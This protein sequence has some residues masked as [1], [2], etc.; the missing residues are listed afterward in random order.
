MN[1][2]QLVAE[3]QHKIDC[4]EYFIDE[5]WRMVLTGKSRPLSE[6][7]Y[8]SFKTGDIYNFI[9]NRLPEAEPQKLNTEK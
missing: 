8:S 9:K 4:Y 7:D 5:I 2:V 6:T 1:E 3:M